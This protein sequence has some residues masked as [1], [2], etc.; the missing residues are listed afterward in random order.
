MPSDT[1]GLSKDIPDVILSG[2][3][4]PDQQR[5][6]GASDYTMGTSSC[7]ATP[8]GTLGPRQDDEENAADP[9]A[10]HLRAPETLDTPFCDAAPAERQGNARTM[11]G[12]RGG[13]CR[14]MSSAPEDHRYALC[15][16]DPQRRP[17]EL[18]Y[19]VY[20]P[21]ERQDSDHTARREPEGAKERHA[22]SQC[23]IL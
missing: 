16:A 4:R 18:Q 8:A 14:P 2:R 5:N 23:R 19:A 17:G 6:F 21:Q 1:N 20:T 9:W 7:E 22:T 10:A 15:E 11:P 13:R 3:I 12:R